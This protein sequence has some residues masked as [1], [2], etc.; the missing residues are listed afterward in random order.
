MTGRYEA[1]LVD[2]I[3]SWADNYEGGQGTA[4]RAIQV[5]RVA[6][7]QRRRQGAP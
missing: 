2:V 3:R 4:L 7:T 5:V 1:P 6:M